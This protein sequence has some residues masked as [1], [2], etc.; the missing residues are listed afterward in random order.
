MDLDGQ[1]FA[2][3]SRLSFCPP[4][5]PPAQWELD[6]R[7]RPLWIRHRDGGRWATVFERRSTLAAMR[8][9]MPTFDSKPLGGYPRIYRTG[10]R[11]LDEIVWRK[12][13]LGQGYVTVARALGLGGGQ[14]A[15]TKVRYQ[16]KIGRRVRHGEGVLPWAAFL[17][18]HISP[19]W[20]RHPDWLRS[21]MDWAAL[22]PHKRSPLQQAL[23]VVGEARTDVLNG[24]EGLPRG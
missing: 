7:G 23:A 3:K 19:D 21:L 5:G 16:V 11:Q 15:R 4:E 12:D 17:E 9:Q 22:Q 20:W 10:R 8:Y 6:G 1:V 24:L 13:I 18:G 2:G 14:S